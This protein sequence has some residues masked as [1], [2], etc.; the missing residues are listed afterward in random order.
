MQFDE[1][2]I[3]F[4]G[5]RYF[6]CANS[7]FPLIDG[8]IE[9]NLNPCCVKI[10]ASFMNMANISGEETVD[11]VVNNEMIHMPI[12]VLTYLKEYYAKNINFDAEEPEEF[13]RHWAAHGKYKNKIIDKKDCMQLICALAGLADVIKTFD[14]SMFNTN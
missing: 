6:G 9:N 3:D 2:M 4:D 7:L 13:N 12:L 11:D 5:G 10:I 8:R 1:A 14:S